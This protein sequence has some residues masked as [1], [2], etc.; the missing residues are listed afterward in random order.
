MASS[1]C[2]KCGYSPAID[3][4]RIPFHSSRVKTL[5]ST[6]QGL[7]E[8]EERDFKSF[9]AN[10]SSKLSRLDARI[11][12]VKNLLEDLESARAE[13]DL[14]L[15][16]RKKILHPM[17]SMPTDLLVEIFKHGSGLYDDPKDLF[18]SNWHS[19]DITS[20]PW[21]YGHV[22]QRWQD[23]STRSPKLW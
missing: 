23:I 13:L 20:S 7:T 5:L 14:A 10:G 15:T 19:L 4:P 21:V 1:D 12:L 22:C 11:E 17:R 8:D 2:P 18:R 16:E 6:N 9:I 3:V